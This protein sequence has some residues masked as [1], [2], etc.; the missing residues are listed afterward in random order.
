ML[1]RVYNPF[2]PY[3]GAQENVTLLEH[4]EAEVQLAQQA[5]PAIRT[6]TGGG[7]LVFAKGGRQKHGGVTRVYGRLMGCPDFGWL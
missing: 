2:L 7:R 4:W 6:A 1:P 5:A 3:S